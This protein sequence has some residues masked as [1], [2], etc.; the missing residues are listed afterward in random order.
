MKKDARLDQIVKL[1]GR[2]GQVTIAE[3]AGRMQV[4]EITIRRDLKLLENLR[5]IKKTGSGYAAY[6]SAHV[7]DV[8]D[9]HIRSAQRSH[10]ENKQY[11]GRKAVSL[12]RAGDTVIFDSGS[13][14]L[15]MVRNLPEH[16]QVRAVCYGLEVAGELRK[17]RVQQLIVLGGVYHEEMDMFEGLADMDQIQSIRAQKAFISAFGVHRQAGLTSGSF[18]ASS[19]RRQ[20]I[21]SAEEVVLLADSS[22]FGVLECA[23]FAGLDAPHLY[24]T[25]GGISREYRELLE[26]MHKTFLIV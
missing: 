15:H 17:K 26:R 2:E 24:I 22:K 18:F 19:I 23:H 8:A 20:I 6:D 7:R 11:I 13:T 3:L 5:L 16:P 21:A 14:L 4:S 12:L 9:Y 25:D 10:A 1:C